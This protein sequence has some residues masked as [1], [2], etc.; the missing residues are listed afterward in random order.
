LNRKCYW[1]EVGKRDRQNLKEPLVD[2]AKRRWRLFEP[3]Q[4]IKWEPESLEFKNGEPPR[5][6]A[7]YDIAVLL[8]DQVVVFR[9]QNLFVSR[10]RK[11]VVR[12]AMDYVTKRLRLK[13]NP[14]ED[15]IVN[16]H[17]PQGKHFVGT[18]LYSNLADA[19][20]ELSPESDIERLTLEEFT[21]KRIAEDGAPQ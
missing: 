2:A 11:D 15:S 21:K 3:N 20:F 12:L 18:L 8:G 16:V 10:N 6:V 17:N 14:S 5:L 9:N 1:R 4:L 13:G 7:S 19:N